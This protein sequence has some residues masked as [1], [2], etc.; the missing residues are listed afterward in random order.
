M[1]VDAKLHKMTVRI[2]DD[3]YT[4]LNARVVADKSNINQVLT[5]AIQSYL[6][7]EKRDVAA[8]IS[9]VNRLTSDFSKIRET[10]DLFVLLMDEFL[11]FFFF[12]NS[13]PSNSEERKEMSESGLVGKSRFENNV[14]ERLMK[15]ESVISYYVDKMRESTGESS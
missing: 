4:R 14:M 5:N 11:K 7:N 6:G 15:N 8:M 13:I 10:Q 3:L 1:G 9:I 12:F 2:S